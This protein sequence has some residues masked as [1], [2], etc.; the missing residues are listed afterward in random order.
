[1]VDLA[2][3][4]VNYKTKDLILNCLKGIAQS[5]LPFSTEIWVVDNSS[6][7]GSVQSIK[8]RFPKVKIIE[9]QINLGFAGG[10]NLGFRKAKAR[11]YLL[12][13]SDT[14]IGK[15]EIKNLYKFGQFSGYGICSCKLLNKNR[16]F[17][18]NAGE[19]P[20]PI[21][22]FLWLSGLDDLLNKFMEVKSYQT[23]NLKTY[24]ENMTVGWV[25]GA[26]MLI[27]KE[28]IDRIGFLDEKIFMY[29]EDVEYC[30]RANKRGIKTGWTNQAE[31]VHFGGGS[32]SSSKY[33]QW[34]GE[35]RGLLYLY[36][37]FYGSFARI[38]LKTF[39]YLFVFLRAIAFLI[40]GRKE[41]AKTYAKIL[42]SF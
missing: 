7:D 24:R 29:G 19:L 26:F 12:V 18:P 23:R 32:P 31:I 28:T 36:K 14:E 11:N 6:L 35:F 8:S 25:S 40:I 22:L 2:I 41:Y 33:T 30:W 16:S 21:S 1:M 37:K 13:N 27:K 9:S 5:E 10:N 17:Q 3:I 20:K 34:L 15:E 4:I 42:T 39:I 38:I